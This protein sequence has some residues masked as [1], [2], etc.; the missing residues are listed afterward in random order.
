MVEI[1]KLRLDEKKLRKKILDHLGI[2]IGDI[3]KEDGTDIYGFYFG[4]VDVNFRDK[5]VTIEYYLSPEKVAT[6]TAPKELYAGG[7]T[8]KV[9][10]QQVPKP[11]ILIGKELEE[12]QA[13]FKKP[14]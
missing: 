1:K 7:E 9:E 3:I 13:K 6:Y 4:H 14:K 10:Y 11:K 8:Y 5:H 2:S 12:Y